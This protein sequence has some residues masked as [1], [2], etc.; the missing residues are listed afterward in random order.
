[1]KTS[2]RY[3]TAELK[4]TAAVLVTDRVDWTAHRISTTYRQRWPTETVYQDSTGHLGRD[5]Y[6][7]RGAEAIGKHWCPVFVAYSSLHLACLGRSLQEGRVLVKT[8]G[9]AC[10]QRA[11]ALIQQLLLYTPDRLL[12]GVALDARFAHLFAKQRRLPR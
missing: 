12:R 2:S 11:A 7:M 9:E 10:R 8:I 5:D 1:M 3:A 4:G 6:R